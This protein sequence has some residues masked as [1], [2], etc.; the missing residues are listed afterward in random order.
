M[1][2]CIFVIIVVN[3]NT[4]WFAVAATNRPNVVFIM[5]DD[6]RGN[7]RAL[8][9]DLA[10]TPNMDALLSKSF[11]F[12]SVF[13]QQ[14]L[15]APSRNSMLTSRRPD[16]ILTYNFQHYWRTFAGNYTTLPQYFKENGYQT[17]SIGKIFHHGPS[18]NK[19]DD[20]PYSWSNPTFI[21]STQEYRNRPV[22]KNQG[23]DELHRNLLC[24][25]IVKFQPEQTLPDI[26]ST[27]AAKEFLMEAQEPFFL[28]IGFYKPHIPFKFPYEYLKYHDI[29]NFRKDFLRPFDLPQAAWNPFNDLRDRDDVKSLNVSYP[30]GPIPSEFAAKIRQHYYAS[31]TYIDSLLGEILKMIDFTNT[32]VVL[33]S[34]HGWSCGEHGEWAKYSNYEVSLRV[35]L[36]IFDPE[37]PQSKMR[38]INSIAELIDVF[39]TLVDIAGL[40]KV[41]KCNNTLEDNLTCTEGKSLHH[42]MLNDEENNDDNEVAF[43]QYP[44]P[45]TYPTKIPDSDQ[46]KLREIKIMGYTIRTK[47]F[48]YT[49]WIKFNNKKFKRNWNKIY[50]EEL[51][52]HDIDDSENINLVHRAEFRQL[53][54]QLKEKLMK[55]FP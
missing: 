35:P 50:G 23:D 10:V 14:A 40:P 19:T 22:C 46:P 30:F 20:Y 2:L 39:P 29:N 5:L 17:E 55:K 28:G 8:G 12:S 27:E 43:S 37:R 44:R 41:S 34:D 13:A 4:N 1:K 49:A 24:P 26:Q 51:Y 25:V 54:N 42:K 21:P 6:F 53:K 36:I 3:F 11:Y 7:I 15:C 16:T 32:I 33:T 18:S 47:R 38:R 45:G 9:D 48:R 31:V 52:D